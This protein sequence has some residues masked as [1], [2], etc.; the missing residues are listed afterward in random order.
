MHLF[1]HHSGIM[2]LSHW[3]HTNIMCKETLQKTMNVHRG[4]EPMKK[5][6]TQF[7]LSNHCKVNL[8]WN[9]PTFNRYFEFK[10]CIKREWL[11]WQHLGVKRGL[12]FYTFKTMS[13]FGTSLKRSKYSRFLHMELFVGLIL[14]SLYSLEETFRM[15]GPCLIMWNKLL[16][17]GLHGMSCIL[18]IIL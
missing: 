4:Y 12:W 9:S 11:H 3:Y 18:L 17:D 14:S 1:H 15:H 6:S 2:N 7:P 10:K 5:K 8:W 16:K 13:F